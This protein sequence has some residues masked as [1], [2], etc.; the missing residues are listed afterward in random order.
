MRL[1]TFASFLLVWF[2]LSPM[3]YSQPMPKPAKFNDYRA[4]WD[5]V[6]KKNS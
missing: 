6:A 1:S 4:D 2:F 3:L 5:L